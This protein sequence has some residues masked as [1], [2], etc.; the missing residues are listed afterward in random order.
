MTVW[1]VMFSGGKVI[2]F[3][4]E[5]K[6]RHYLGRIRFSRRGGNRWISECGHFNAK[7]EPRVLDEEIE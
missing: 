7:V 5:V 3:S 1:I 2:A 6:A 4:T